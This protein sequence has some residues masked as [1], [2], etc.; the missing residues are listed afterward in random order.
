VIDLPPLVAVPIS[1]ILPWVCGYLLLSLL[2]VRKNPGHVLLLTGHGYFLGM[3]LV[4]YLLRLWY[5]LGLTPNFLAIALVF[6]SLTA[7]TR[8][9]A[10]SRPPPAAGPPGRGLQ[11]WE[12]VCIVILLALLVCRY[13]TIFQEVILRPLF[14]WDAW[15]N[16]APKA[17]I[18][19][20]EKTLVPFVNYTDWLA[21][22]SDQQ[23]FTLGNKVAWKYPE[24]VP[25]VQLWGMLATGT[26]DSTSI[27]LSW[28]LLAVGVGCALYGHLRVAGL[29]VL[30]SLLAVYAL[31]N[32]PYFN[33]HAALAGYADIW[34]AAAFGLGIMALQEWHQRREYAY[35]VL[36]V[37]YAIA[38][39]QT[40]LP[41]LVLGAILLAVMLLTTVRWNRRRLLFL[42]SPFVLLVLA[43]LIGLDLDLP[44]LGRIAI[45]LQEIE[46]PV[47]GQFV[48]KFHNV[49][50]A[51]LDSALQMLNW[52]LL[53][54]VVPLFLL[55]KIQA[56]GL[57]QAP[58]PTLLC[59]SLGC[60]FLLFVFYLTPAYLT[61]I[62]QVTLNRAALYI[63]PPIIYYLF[64]EYPQHTVAR[65]YPP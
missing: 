53:C 56:G 46:L 14:P 52:N 64:R 9:L 62:T 39:F 31:L 16:W 37:V 54:Y 33:V 22:G 58:S 21:A 6:A 10:R 59:I 51:I 24:T 5:T 1:L 65:T 8:W 38:C 57:R 12:V 2:F 47:L 23:V 44:H 60:G 43:A 17:V 36:T 7:I 45:S 49:S 42:I 35:A 41:G 15:M 20:Y 29:G 28:P 13:Y 50:D 3:L 18:W 34:M 61:A 32:M 55:W 27:Y 11:A 48:I 63:V 19:F 40:K 4:T 30:L 25:L 26:S